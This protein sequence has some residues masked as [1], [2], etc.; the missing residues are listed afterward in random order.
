MDINTDTRAGR[1]LKGMIEH[2]NRNAAMRVTVDITGQRALHQTFRLKSWENRDSQRMVTL[3]LADGS[4][5]AGTYATKV[6]HW[7]TATGQVFPAR[8]E[9]QD[10]KLMLWAAARALS[11]CQTGTFPAPGN[12][13]LNVV[14][15]SRCGACGRDLDHPVSVELGIGPEC[16]KRCGL[17][18]H[19]RGQTI[20]GSQRRKNGKAAPAAEA[21]E[22]QAVADQADDFG[23]WM[24]AL[25]KTPVAA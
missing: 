14:E 8:G 17:E 12:G 15:E 13:T 16:A 4:W 18:H 25:P 5:D 22:Q 1:M 21:V 11:Y 3:D 20:K 24:R 9:F 23:D 2:G 19:Y 6:L 7:N 10:D